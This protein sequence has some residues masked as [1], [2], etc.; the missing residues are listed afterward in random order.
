LVF[1]SQIAGT[2]PNIE[3]YASY[4]ID[5]PYLSH[6]PRVVAYVQQEAYGLSSVGK[7]ANTRH[8]S[9]LLTMVHQI[10]RDKKKFSCVRVKNFK[11]VAQTTPLSTD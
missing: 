10:I 4:L 9:V 7:K 11:Y 2:Q 3:M 6:L 1:C 5:P 8:Y